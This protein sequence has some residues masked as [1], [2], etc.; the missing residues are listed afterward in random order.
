MK[1]CDTNLTIY[2]FSKI[3]TDIESLT[4]T[5]YHLDKCYQS[6]TNEKRYSFHWNWH[7]YSG[8]GEVYLVNGRVDISNQFCVQS[9]LRVSTDSIRKAD[10]HV[11][12]VY[13]EP[14]LAELLQYIADKEQKV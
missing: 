12:E 9:L 14:N 5:D 7:G 8:R 3:M 4:I 1:Q 11:S 6:I 13:N 2:D 10:K